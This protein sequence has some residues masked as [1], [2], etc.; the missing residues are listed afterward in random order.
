MIRFIR[1]FASLLRGGLELL[2]V[3]LGQLA[4]ELAEL[5]RAASRTVVVGFAISSGHSDLLLAINF[6]PNRYCLFYRKFSFAYF[7]SRDLAAWTIA[8]PPLITGWAYFAPDSEESF[9]VSLKIQKDHSL[10]LP[11][12]RMILYKRS[13][14]L[15]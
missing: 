11:L 12:S 5:A 3:V 7:C 15:S 9:A 10:S 4:S 6:Y 8:S 14:G 2:V 13:A 1:Y